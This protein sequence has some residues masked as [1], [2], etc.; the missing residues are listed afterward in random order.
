MNLTPFLLFDGNCAEAMAFYQACLG[1]ELTVTKVGDTPMKDQHS[2]EQ[3][4]KVIYAH[5]KSGSIEFSATDWL[6]L[7]RRPNPGNTVA[8]YLNSG[9]YG[10]L[11]E[12]FDKLSVGADPELLDALR[13]LPFGTYGHLADTYGVHW[14][15]QGD[16]ST[17]SG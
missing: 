9:T 11:R 7:T 14:F 6:H 5:L 16:S 8:M 4:S 10:Q 3:H 15:F 2:P 1:G 13:D 17:A 12:V